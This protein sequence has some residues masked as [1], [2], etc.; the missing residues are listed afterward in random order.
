MIKFEIIKNEDVKEMYKKYIEKGIYKGKE[1][2]YDKYGRCTLSNVKKVD[3]EK[4]TY[5]IHS[6][7]NRIKEAIYYGNTFKFKDGL[8]QNTGNDGL[9]NLLIKNLGKNE[10]NVDKF[11]DYMGAKSLLSLDDDAFK[12]LFP[13]QT[14][15]RRKE[16]LDIAKQ[17]DV[18]EKYLRPLSFDAFIYLLKI[19]SFFMIISSS[20]KKMCSHPRFKRKL[21]ASFLQTDG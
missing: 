14:A 21:I 2:I 12:G 8:L 7:Y 18:K 11:F 4:E 10:K 3:I 19:F 13:K 5:N 16:F 9:Q 1:H 15:T 20:I 6:D 17:G